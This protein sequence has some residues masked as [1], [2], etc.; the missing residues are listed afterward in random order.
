MLPAIGLVVL[1]A[2]SPTQRFE[3]YVQAWSLRVGVPWGQLRTPSDFPRV[4]TSEHMIPAGFARNTIAQTEPDS[5]VAGRAQIRV[6]PRRIGKADNQELS[7]WALH[8]VCHVRLGH[9]VFRFNV[10]DA[11]ELD[12]QHKACMAN[13]VTS[14]RADAHQPVKK[15]RGW[16]KWLI[17]AAIVLI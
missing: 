16:K 17:L 10:H 6:D 12:A 3:N 8:E 13:A 2:A 5:N 7:R 9:Q 15:G 11:P 14:A 1:A 4:F